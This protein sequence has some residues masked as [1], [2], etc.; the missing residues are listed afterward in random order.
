MLKNIK[1]STQI[2]TLNA[3]GIAF[4]VILSLQGFFTF[5]AINESLSEIRDSTKLVKEQTLTL[6]N[7]VK[8]IKLNIS[9]TKMEA[10]ESIVS[11]KPVSKNEHYNKALKTA[12]SELSNLKN[13][14]NKYKKSKK[15]LHKFHANLVKDFKT[16]YLILE[17][18]QE[19]IEEDEEYGRE[20]LSDEVKPIEE[21]L[22]SALD[23]LVE[24]T[25][26]K[27]NKKFSEI[28]TE[29]VQADSLANSS[30]V[31]N[32][33]ISVIATILFLVIGILIS[34]NITS[35][36]K[37]FKKSLIGFLKYLE[38]ETD[39]IETLD[40]SN[41]EIGE[42]SKAVNANILVIKKDIEQDSLV[43]KDASNVVNMITSGNLNGRIT[44][45]ANNPAINE[46]TE[47]LNSMMESLQKVILYSL[48]T[49]K[50]YQNEDFRS[51]ITK[52]CDGEI[53]DLMNGIND[54][55]DKIS[56]MLVENKSNGLTLQHS[57]DTLLLNV[58]EL[59][60]ASNE[61]AASLEETAAALDEITSNIS[62][63]T[64]KVIQMA[65]YANELNKSADHGS[66]LANKTTTAMDEINSEVTAISEAISVIDQI[67]F[68][69]NILSL[70]AA[71]EAATAGEAGKGFA[72][73]AGEVRNLASRSA[74]AANEIKKLVDNATQKASNGKVIAD[75]MIQDYEGLNENINQTIE[76]ISD[77]ENSSKDQQIGIE[78]INNAISSLDQQTQKNANVATNTQSIANQT[79]HLA[80]AIV[81]SANSKEFNGKDS[82][83]IKNIEN[84]ND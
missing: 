38:R 54:L 84:K 18:L 14:L 82:V 65:G 43:I 27:F 81:D 9:L 80:N 10:F 36:I 58:E 39:T 7:I 34:K 63:N 51:K 5:S 42:M 22:F 75:K 70:N 33:S 15:D 26:K 30:K 68:Q 44:Q 2:Y 40:E 35:L 16:Y 78:Q 59:N 12:K 25:N 72:V 62:N 64:Q 41:N 76:L 20:I 24:R 1:L 53:C 77:I 50:E 28:S 3:I 32:I 49:L 83:Q 11:K 6:N 74:E 23:K 57:S 56:Q 21:K 13:F 47:V 52:N 73:V 55:G 29:I 45:K 19:E 69:T 4:F 37:S 48:E 66:E 60:R 71:V 17:V 67:S 61:A 31:K 46:L 79:Q 8:K